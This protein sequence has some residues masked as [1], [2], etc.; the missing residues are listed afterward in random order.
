MK[1]VHKNSASN[2]MPRGGVER[3]IGTTNTEECFIKPRIIQTAF[4]P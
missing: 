2:G 1:V 4:E 3:I